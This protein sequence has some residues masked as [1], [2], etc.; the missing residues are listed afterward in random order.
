MFL[1]TLLLVIVSAWSL[2]TFLRLRKASGK[3][4]DDRVF[5]TACQVSS[6]YVHTGVIMGVIITLLALGIL[7]M[8]SRQ[9]YKSF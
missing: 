7:A 4:K 9:L 5:E 8:A 1:L 3:Y 2:G 6:M